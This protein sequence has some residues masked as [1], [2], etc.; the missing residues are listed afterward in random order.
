MRK[1]APQYDLRGDTRKAKKWIPWAQQQIKRLKNLNAGNTVNKV[2]RPVFGVAVYLRSIGDF[3]YIR[4]AVAL[5]KGACNLTGTLTPLG[6]KQVN[7]LYNYEFDDGS[8]SQNTVMDSGGLFLTG[9]NRYS[10]DSV[11]DGEVDYNKLFNNTGDYTISTYAMSNSHGSVFHDSGIMSVPTYQVVMDVSSMAPNAS[12]HIVGITPAFDCYANGDFVG[13][14]FGTEYRRQIYSI[15]VPV[16][17]TM[18]M[19]FV[20]VT[21]NIRLVQIR[22]KKYICLV[23]DTQDITVT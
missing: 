21:T 22:F 5:A 1:R 19:D 12:M 15:T 9:N 16:E 4:I 20:A 8:T 14:L 18:T 6:S 10:E 3:D 23:T 7:F 11:N 13:R 2:L 17:D